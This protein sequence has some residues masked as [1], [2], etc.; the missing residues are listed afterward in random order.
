VSLIGLPRTEP[1]TKKRLM[2]SIA[3]NLA[4]KNPGING[5]D[6]AIFIMESPDE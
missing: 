3:D 6:I 2:C 1:W 5:R 4:K